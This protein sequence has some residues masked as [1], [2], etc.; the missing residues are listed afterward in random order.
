MT[1]EEFVDNAVELIRTGAGWYAAA[2]ELADLLNDQAD[3]TVH[4]KAIAEAENARA[5]TYANIVKNL[6]SG[7]SIFP[8]VWQLLRRQELRSI[9]LKVNAGQFIDLQK[10]V[11]ARLDELKGSL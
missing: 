5:N 6:Q 9:G 8:E 1:H 2:K 4:W 7:G 10:T 11:I 3:I